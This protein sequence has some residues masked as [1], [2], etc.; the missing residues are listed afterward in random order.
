M[1]ST[2]L[3]LSTPFSDAVFLN[4]ARYVLDQM[5]DNPNF[6]DPAPPLTDL[7]AAI[8]AFSDAIVASDAGTHSMVAAKNERREELTAVYVQLGLYVMYVAVGNLAILVSSGYPVSKQREPVYIT[9]PGNVTLKQGVTS[10]D[11]QASV[12]TVKGTR[13][14][15]FQYTDS[16]PAEG[17]TWTTQ[18]TTRR[19]LTF[20][21]LVPGKKYWVRVAVTGAGEQIAY[22]TVASQFVL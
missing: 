14:Y 7:A 2:K 13:T 19:A 17:V 12:D 4:K 5:T 10:G 21:G 11:L 20:K 9:N 18:T 8:Q 6:V 22:S 1:M 16:E 15:L 3:N